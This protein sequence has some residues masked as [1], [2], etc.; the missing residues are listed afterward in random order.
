MALILLVAGLLWVDPFG[1]RLFDRLQGEQDV[2]IT[3]M[4]PETA[5]YL[6]IDLLQFQSDEWQQV[7]APFIEAAGDADG[8]SA[9]DALQ[10]QIEDQFNISYEDDVRPWLGSS[11]GVSLLDVETDIGGDIVAVQWVLAVETRNNRDSDAFLQKLADGWATTTGLTA[12]SQTYDDVDLTQFESENPV[13]QLVFGRVDNLVL[14]GSDVD[15]VQ[16]AIDARAD[17]SLADT[18]GYA[19]LK[20][21]LVDGRLAT[22]Y[23]N[24]PRLGPLQEAL[25]LRVGAF[26]LPPLPTDGI[27]GTA[28][29]ISQHP[30]GIQLDAT[31]AY[32]PGRLSEPQQQLLQTQVSGAQTAENLSPDT[33]LYLNG[34]G[35]NHLWGVYRAAF[36]DIASEA[37]FDESMALL[38]Q[39]FGLNPDTELL[40]FLDG[41]TAV[42]LIPDTS[43]ALSQLTNSGVELVLVTATNDEQSLSTYVARFSDTFNNTLGTVTQSTNANSI[44]EYQLET[45][46]LP[47]YS[48]HYGLGQSTFLLATSGDAL[49][50]GQVDTAVSLAQ[51]PDFQA[52]WSQYPEEMIPGLYVDVE[53]WLANVEE[54][55]TAVLPILQPIETLSA[56]AQVENNQTHYQM[57]I[58]V[59]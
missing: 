33:L 7:F 16:K 17:V 50:A 8:A 51:T 30:T 6:S 22:I 34:V 28:V 56:A 13:E 11:L 23:V 37:D 49:Q 44:T 27:R 43:G 57:I 19:Q 21:T 42:A 10:A 48:L 52:V 1:W 55:G 24:M 36:I 12:V 5:V 40:P 31:T 35:V 9:Q 18:S 14:V 41:E 29:S 15:G 25:P 54:G 26:T 39:Q 32:E 47:D 58:A 2:A 4:P 53:R 45:I 59:K 20:P 46:L 3:A 38:Q